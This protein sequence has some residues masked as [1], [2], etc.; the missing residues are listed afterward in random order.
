LIDP[1]IIDSFGSSFNCYTTK[2]NEIFKE[3]KKRQK[4][5]H[6]AALSAFDSIV[7]KTHGNNT[8]REKMCTK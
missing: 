4:V 1:Q 8:T 7:E 6:E 3:N 2:E 5:I